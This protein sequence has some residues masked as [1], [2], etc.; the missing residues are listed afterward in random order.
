MRKTGRA[1]KRNNRT[2]RRSGGASRVYYG[3]I[4]DTNGNVRTNLNFSKGNNRGTNAH[5]QDINKILSA[6]VRE[7]F[8][9]EEIVHD[10]FGGDD[11]SGVVVVKSTKSLPDLKF[12]V[13]SKNYTMNF[14]KFENSD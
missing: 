12:S 6:H 2:K 9:D 4:T 11:G 14:G 1:N 8:T 7:T 5:W 13:G 3:S 10:G